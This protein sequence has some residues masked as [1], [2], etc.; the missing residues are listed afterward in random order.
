MGGITAAHAVATKIMD[1]MILNVLVGGI[2]NFL[3][4]TASCIEI[5]PFFPSKDPS[6]AN[7]TFN[8]AIWLKNGGFVCELVGE[9]K[10]I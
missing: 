10:N 2:G 6:D 5:T 1:L 4:C 7:H 9:A 3:F 8:S